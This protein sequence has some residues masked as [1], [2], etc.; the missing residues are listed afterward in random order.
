MYDIIQEV[1]KAVS[2]VVILFQWCTSLRHR[3]M[4]YMSVLCMI[5]LNVAI[6]VAEYKNSVCC[7]NQIQIIIEAI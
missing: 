3:G 2:N 1:F 4:L 5:E 6:N 7:C